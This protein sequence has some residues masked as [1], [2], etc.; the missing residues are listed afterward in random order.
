VGI[1]VLL[2]VLGLALPSH[3]ADKVPLSVGALSVAGDPI[4]QIIQR[5]KI[6]LDR[7]APDR[8]ET[9]LLIRGQAGGEEALMSAV[10]RGRMNMA[11]FTGSG[12]SAVVP[13]FSV[14]MAPYL[15]A[16]YGELDF[17]LDHFLAEPLWRLAEDQNLHVFGWLDDGWISL[18]AKDPLLVPKD[19]NGYPM[20]AWQVPTSHI[21]FETLGADTIGMSFPDLIPALQTGLVRG[22]EIAPMFYDV[23]GMAEHAPHYIL[24]QHA[25]NTGV[26]A[27]NKE[28]LD[29]LKEDERNAV[30]AA[31]PDKI[32][33]RAL[34]RGGVP[35]N[36]ASMKAQGAII[37]ALTERQQA[38]WAAATK[39]AHEAL[40]QDL[41]PQAR[42]LYA[43]IQEGKTAYANSL[44]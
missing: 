24:T 6:G 31:V 28:W 22:S 32:I 12:M 7:I 33:A 4:D 42:A 41:G 18:Y 15:F 13:E 25:Y 1:H 44:Q 20:R 21:F 2:L 19:V 36:Y 27:A 11:S 8:F 40:L 26:L 23:V 37:H 14:T 5:F 16:S 30:I 34:L 9:K 38:R 3:A 10:R 29:S 35:A 17:V 43:L 39:P